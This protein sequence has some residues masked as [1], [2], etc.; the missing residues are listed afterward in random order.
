MGKTGEGSWEAAKGWSVIVLGMGV[1]PSRHSLWPAALGTSVLNSEGG[2]Y[3]AQCAPCS[4]LAFG[5]ALET[6]PGSGHCCSAAVELLAGTPSD[7]PL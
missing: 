1:Q 2:T 7:T 5:P 6:T 4:S 3:P